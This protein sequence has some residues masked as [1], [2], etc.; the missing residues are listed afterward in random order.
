MRAVDPRLCNVRIEIDKHR[1]DV[2]GGKLAVFME[3]HIL[4]DVAKGKELCLAGNTV[5]SSKCLECVSLMCMMCVLC[6]SEVS[7]MSTV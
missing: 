3:Y 6:V 5:P 4:K 2:V 7:R 1:E